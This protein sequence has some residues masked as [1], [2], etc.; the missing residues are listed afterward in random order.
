MAT[1]RPDSG[2][3]AAS[4]MGAV[5]RGFAAR[6]QRKFGI[7]REDE[8]R[9]EQQKRQDA[10]IAKEQTQYDT[11]YARELADKRADATTLYDRQVGIAGMKNPQKMEPPDLKRLQT[12]LPNMALN[13]PASF[14]EVNRIMSEGASAGREIPYWEAVRMVAKDDLKSTVAADETIAAKLQDMGLKPGQERISG[15]DVLSLLPQYGFGTQGVAAEGEYTIDG[16]VEII[17]NNL[18][19]P[20]TIYNPAYNQLVMLGSALYQILGES[21]QR[22]DPFVGPPE[23]TSVKVPGGGEFVPPDIWGNKT[24][25]AIK[26]AFD[27]TAGQR[28]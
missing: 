3:M 11:R 1:N 26:G 12:L 6:Q 9:L 14:E 28:R 20:Q 24:F 19:S 25:Q 22:K 17:G 13:Y 5:M 7:K 21:E 27:A 4:I 2:A 15:Q 16:L 18:S 10:L 23:P 8:L